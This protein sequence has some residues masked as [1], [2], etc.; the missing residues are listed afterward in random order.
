VAAGAE[1][2]FSSKSSASVFSRSA[3][4]VSSCKVYLA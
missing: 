2:C 1:F 4:S 3:R